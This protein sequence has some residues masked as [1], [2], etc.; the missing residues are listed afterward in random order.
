GKSARAL[1]A[2]DVPRVLS[3]WQPLGELLDA[4]P[5]RSDQSS[6]RVADADAGDGA[7]RGDGSGREAGERVS[8]PEP[9]AGQPPAVQP[10]PDE[11]PGNEAAGRAGPEQS[12]RDERGD[13][14]GVRSEP[15]AE[16]RPSGLDEFDAGF[17][18]ALGEL[19][20]TAPTSSTE[21]KQQ[22]EK[23]ARTS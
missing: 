11:R 7:S 21:P 8:Q 9:E 15:P 2:V 16:R 18:A 17:D 10:G 12:A 1:P 23:R 14:A 13:T 20:G 19:F 4:V 22:Q 3:A 6:D 5:G